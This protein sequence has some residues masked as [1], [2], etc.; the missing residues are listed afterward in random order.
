MRQTAMFAVLVGLFGA[1]LVALALWAVR[2]KDPQR[3]VR[4]LIEEAERRIREIER[5][6]EEHD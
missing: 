3:R 6:I 2:N 5:L 4:R 1:A